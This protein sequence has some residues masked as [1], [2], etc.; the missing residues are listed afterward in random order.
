MSPGTSGGPDGRARLPRRLRFRHVR[1][2][3]IAARL[4]YTG[5]RLSIG[6]AGGWGLVIDS[7]VYRNILG[8][9]RDI[10]KK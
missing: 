9:W 1:F 3:R 5:P 2:N 10:I 6:S 7:R 4:T 8:G